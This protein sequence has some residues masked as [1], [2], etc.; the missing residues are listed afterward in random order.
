MLLSIFTRWR[1]IL[2]KTKGGEKMIPDEDIWKGCENDINML[3]WAQSRLESDIMALDH[4]EQYGLIPNDPRPSALASEV[5]LIAKIMG[6]NE[7][8]ARIRSA[9]KN[10]RITP[11]SY[12]W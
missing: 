11:K 3:P 10:W 9:L 5:N 4:I 2:F 12:C 6:E 7:R 1:Q 8:I